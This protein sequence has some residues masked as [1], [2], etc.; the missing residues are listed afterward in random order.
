VEGE[1]AW[2]LLLLPIRLGGMAKTASITGIFSIYQALRRFAGQGGAFQL[3]LMMR[4][5]SIKSMTC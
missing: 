3:P 5:N 4:K 2:P 1:D